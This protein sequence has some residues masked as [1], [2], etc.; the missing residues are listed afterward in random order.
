MNTY[1]V[2]YEDETQCVVMNT[3]TGRT[4]L[5]VDYDDA[6]TNLKWVESRSG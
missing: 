5:G 3:A 6:L 4:M 2:S 1:M